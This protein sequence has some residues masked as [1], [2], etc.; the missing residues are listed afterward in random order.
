MSNDAP[1]PVSGRQ[2]TISADGYRAVVSSVGASL[3]VLEHEGRP[4][5]SSFPEDSLRPGYRGAVLVPW[6]NRVVDGRYELE[7]Q[8]HR[9]ALTEPARGHALHGLGTWADWETV[10]R[11]ESS[12]TLGVTI[13]PQPG[14]P[15]RVRSEVTYALSGDGLRWSVRS[16]NL[17]TGLAPYGTGPHPYLVAGP[18]LVDEWT[19]TI[20]AARVLT[21]TERLAPLGLAD[22]ATYDDGR[23]DF[24]R[25]RVLGDTFI[26]H[27]FTG[28]ESDAAGRSR[29][30]VRSPSGTGVEMEWDGA[31]PWLQV[32]TPD[33][34]GDLWRTGLAVEPM[35][36]PPDAFNSRQDVVWLEPGASHAVGWTIRAL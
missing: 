14:Y 16:T 4:L 28:C 3:R 31:S 5:V 27:A 13:P 35:T 34:P 24:R 32:H 9:L 20:P 6:P 19:V 25:P 18:E 2:T 29:V 7:G 1:V 23:L 10:D 22:V 17:G 30:E 26:D 15:F 8:E 12:V 11:S 33:G 21:V 36:C